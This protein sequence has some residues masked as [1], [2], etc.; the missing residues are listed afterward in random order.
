[1][2]AF[3]RWIPAVS[4]LLVSLISYVDRN[5]LAL[6]APTILK[7]TGLSGQQYGFIIAVFSVA[8]MATNPLWG[9]I[10]DRVGLPV[11]MAVAV[12]LWTA[13]S[14]AHAWASGFASFAIARLALGLGEGAT[15]PGGLRAVMQS[16][17]A[18]LHGRGMAVAYSGGSLG[19]VVTPLV[20]TPVFLLWGW[21]AA[22]LFTGLIGIAWLVFWFF[23]AGRPD[24]Q[25]PAHDQRA[26]ARGPTLRDPRL[27]AFVSA[28]ALGAWPLGFVL[29]QS[30]IFLGQAMGKS[31][32]FIGKVLW[33]PPLGW[34]VGYFFWG[35]LMDRLAL[36]G[37]PRMAALH[38]LIPAAAL[39]SL[40]LALVPS[41]DSV[42]L[43]L[44]EMFFAMFLAGGFVTLGI[45]YAT[46]V[47]SRAHAGLIAGIG[48]G[49]W[50]AA[51]ALAMPIAGRLFDQHRYDIAFLIPAVTP[52]I[53]YSGWLALQ[54]L[55]VR[56]P[57]AA[58]TS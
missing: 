53:G 27:W 47:Y 43:V 9:R 52:L 46:H 10:L 16:L 51:V 15:F 18:H 26:A 37:V 38:R 55:P 24:M 30:A 31:Q 56:R 7:E 42:W 1:M 11:G 35:W 19:A 54:K 32:V 29:Y 2:R 50:S 48:A 22:F 14:A 44:A 36:A 45:A 13:A 3:D 28:Y 8:Y 39:L 6:L 4:M 41:M 58:V 57:Q 20:I 21:R 34:E 40:P 23:V 12:S 17:P 5:T 49:S 25:R 33:I